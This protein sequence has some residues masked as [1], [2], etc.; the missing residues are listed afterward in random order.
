[1]RD[2]GSLTYIEAIKRARKVLAS[3]GDQP[4]VAGIPIE[5]E[6]SFTL[7]TTVVQYKAILQEPDPQTALSNI[8]QIFDGLEQTMQ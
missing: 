4:L 8:G 7:S 1:M 2:Y 3:F 6:I 5:L